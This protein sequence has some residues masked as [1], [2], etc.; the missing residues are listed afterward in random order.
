V[1]HSLGI[2]QVLRSGIV[3]IASD[4][5]ESQASSPAVI[6]REFMAAYS[7]VYSNWEHFADQ[8]TPSDKAGRVLVVYDAKFAS[9][10]TKYA[11]SVQQRLGTAPLMYEAP[12][13]SSEIQSKIRSHFEEAESLSYLTIIG[14]D[15]PTMRGSKTGGKECDHCYAMLSG[16]V[17]LD[18]FVGRLSGAT[19]AD[20]EVQLTKIAQYEQQSRCLGYASFWHRFQSGW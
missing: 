5:T 8:Y 13:S 4:A 7:S 20:I 3:E 1:D 2:V 12:S 16:G 9:Q 15:V 19:V 14:R 10:A 18:L 17:S 6:D 11:D